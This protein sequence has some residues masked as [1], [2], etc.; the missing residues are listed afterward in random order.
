MMHPMAHL[1]VVRRLHLLDDLL[2]VGSLPRPISNDGI[3][4]MGR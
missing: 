3:F 1:P 4:E 2:R